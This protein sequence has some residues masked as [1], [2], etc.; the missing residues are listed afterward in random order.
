MGGLLGAG[1]FYTRSTWWGGLGAEIHGSLGSAVFDEG[2]V[3]SHVTINLFVGQ[4]L[5]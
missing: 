2:N 4:N 3:L 1:L 5:R